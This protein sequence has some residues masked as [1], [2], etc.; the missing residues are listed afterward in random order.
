MD[1]LVLGPDSGFLQQG[2]HITTGAYL[3]W[4][5]DMSLGALLLVCWPSVRLPGAC[6]SHRAAADCGSVRQKHPGRTAAAAAA[7]RGLPRQLLLPPAARR[8]RV[9]VLRVSVQYPL[10]RV[11]FPFVCSAASLCGP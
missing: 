3:K 4:T 2:A 9:R 11:S 8:H 10:S 7:G 6:R 5:P 1:A